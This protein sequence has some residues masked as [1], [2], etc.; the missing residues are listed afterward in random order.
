MNLGVL[1]FTNAGVLPTTRMPWSDQEIA[2]VSP[3]MI[4]LP[5]GTELVGY[6]ADG[7]CMQQAG[8]NHCDIVIVQPMATADS[9]QAVIARLDGV[10][11][12][13]HYV[14]EDGTPLLRAADP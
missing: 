7:N 1:D 13:K 6:V 10:Q 12:L 4:G 11:M 8:I 5:L 9:G 3:D 2:W 14:V